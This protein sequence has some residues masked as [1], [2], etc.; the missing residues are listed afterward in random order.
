AAAGLRADPARRSTAHPLPV[1][2]AGDPPAAPGPQTP[3]THDGGPPGAVRR[4]HARHLG[5]APAGAPR[6]RVHVPPVLAVGLGE[7][8]T[9]LANDGPRRL[10]LGVEPCPRWGYGF[11]GCLPTRLVRRPLYCPPGEDHAKG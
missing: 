10:P 11:T 8:G 9:R 7:D 3:R 1:R 4:D 2:A 5:L 6:R